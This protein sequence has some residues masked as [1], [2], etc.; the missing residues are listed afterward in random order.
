MFSNSGG[1]FSFT[2][3]QKYILA[4]S[5][6]NCLSAHA[7]FWNITFTRWS[8]DSL[9]SRAILR[10]WPRNIIVG[11]GWVPSAL[12]TRWRVQNLFVIPSSICAIQTLVAPFVSYVSVAA[13]TKGKGTW[14]PFHLQL[15]RNLPH[16][17]SFKPCP[18]DKNNLSFAW[19]SLMNG[20]LS[21]TDSCFELDFFRGQRLNLFKKPANHPCEAVNS[22]S[23]SFFLTICFA[24]IL[25]HAAKHLLPWERR[26]L[27]FKCNSLSIP[28]N[29]IFDLDIFAPP[30]LNSLL[31][32]TSAAAW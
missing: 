22:E 16:F 1:T 23:V 31:L 18:K 20:I 29:L 25:I 10:P 30:V 11:F 21:R 32:V 27:N 14:S 19:N 26:S 3:G 17:T 28:G 8:Q 6:T 7:F 12:N 24:F 9:S 2:K 4:Q 5:N 15:G 13:Q